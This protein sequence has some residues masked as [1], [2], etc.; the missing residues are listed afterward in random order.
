MNGDRAVIRSLHNRLVEGDDRHLRQA[1]QAMPAVA[2]AVVHIPQRGGAAARTARN[3]T[4]TLRS[5]TVRIAPAEW[6]VENRFDIQVVWVQED[7]PP[8]GDA[9]L[10]WLLLTTEPVATATQALRVLKC[11]TYRWRIEDFHKAWKSVGCDVEAR[12][13]HGAESLDRTAA[14][15]AFIAVRLLQ[16]REAHDTGSKAACSKYLTPL[17]WRCLWLATEKRRPLPKAA[18]DA[19]WACRALAKL[20]GWMPKKGAS[21]GHAKLWKGWDRLSE[22]VDAVLLATEM[23]LGAM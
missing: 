1:I 12:R 13:Q 3:A 11:Y 22:R 18:P 4:V 16:L 23:K 5:G 19:V 14:I 9:A 10:D 6:P 8:A 7:Q 20:G 21:P 15:L 17:Q 2:E